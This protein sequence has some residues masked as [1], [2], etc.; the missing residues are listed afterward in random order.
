M[1]L[2]ISSLILPQIAIKLKM[3]RKITT[4][5]LNL[6]KYSQYLWKI[7]PKNSNFDVKILSLFNNLKT[8]FR[9]KISMKMH[10]IGITSMSREILHQS[11]IQEKNVVNFQRYQTRI[12]IE[13]ALVL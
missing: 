2:K 12:I 5:Y 4:I 9:Q 11:D 7:I 6:L 8:W 3:M 13:D 1:I 10:K